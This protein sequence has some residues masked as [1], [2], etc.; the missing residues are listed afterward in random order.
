MKNKGKI[1]IVDDD[2]DVLRAL[3]LL[4]ETFFESVYPLSTPNRIPELLQ[5]EDFDVLLLDMN[6][7]A[8]INT[9]NEGIY[10]LN[11]ILSIDPSVV[12]I[13]ITA[14]GDIQL[15]VKAIKEGATDFVLKPWDNDKLITTILSAIKLSQSGKK[16]EKLEQK[17][18]QINED[19]NREFEMLNG[20]SQIMKK[21]VS[22]IKKVSKTDANVLIV[23][24]NGTGKELVAREI[25]RLSARND[26]IFIRVDLAS[27]SESIFESEL[28]GYTKGA[29]TDAKEDRK[30][31][32]EIASGGTLF[33]DEIGN[34]SLPLQS[35]ILT[36]LQERNIVP[37]GSNR[38][39][40]FDIR[41][42]SATNK[43]LNKMISDELFREDLLYRL[44]TIV[45]EMPPLRERG[46]DVIIFTEYFLN[47]FRLKYEKPAIKINRQA[48]DK[49]KKHKWPGNVRELQHTIEK[50]VILSESNIL[51]QDDF[52]FYNK[53][54]IDTG[55]ISPKTLEDIEKQALIKALKNNKGVLSDAAKELGI[56]R[57]TMYNKMARYGL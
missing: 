56:A 14:F 32:F 22:T 6:F 21:V 33:L 48:L 12:I 40:S 46:D 52:I 41:L 8:G 34:L 2:K 7:S 11:R 50:A 35:K 23:G 28:F 25:H 29:F 16:I 49:I 55:E 4:L 42:I 30:G 26:E 45:I 18:K 3:E 15:A 54:D 17:Q 9:G 13:L 27:L 51:H 57:Q 37:L 43:N 44:N 38:N 36:A 53:S 19:I 1:L 5:S 24:E 31:R 47:R 20:E 10:W 39:V